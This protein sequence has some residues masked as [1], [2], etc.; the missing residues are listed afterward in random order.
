[1]ANQWIRNTLIAGGLAM[2]PVAHASK[3]AVSLRWNDAQCQGGT[4]CEEKGSICYPGSCSEPICSQPNAYW[5]SD[6]K[7]CSDPT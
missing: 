2:F 3:P 4:C 7:K 5:R 6:G 1:M